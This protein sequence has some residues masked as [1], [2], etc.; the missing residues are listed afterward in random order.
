[1][2][3]GILFAVSLHRPY[4]LFDQAAKNAADYAR[5]VPAIN[6]IISLSLLGIAIGVGIAAIVHLVQTV[7]E[8][9]RLRR[10]D[11]SSAMQ[12]SALL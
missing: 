7:R 5:A 2:T 6:K 9:R 11:R 12:V 10:A 8:L 1:M 4:L 3:L